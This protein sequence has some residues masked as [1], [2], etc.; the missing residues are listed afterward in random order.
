MYT[1]GIDKIAVVTKEFKVLD[2]HLLTIQPSAYRPNDPEQKEESILFGNQKGKKAFF[3]HTAFNTTIDPRGIVVSLNPSKALHPYNLTNNDNEIQQV[4]DF[5]RE[6]MKDAG[7]LIPPDNELKLVRLDMA[8]NSQM[9]FPI[10]FYAPLFQSLKGKRMISKEY[11]SSYYFSN[12]QREINFY[13]KTEEVTQRGEDIPIDP[14][15]MRGELRA[16]KTD[17][18]GRM[19]RFNDLETMLK[20]GGEYRLTKYKQSLVSQIFADGN[21]VDQLSFFSL[22]YARELEVLKMYKE[23][24]NRN[25]ILEWMADNSLDVIIAKFGSLENL[26]MCL[27]DAGYEKKYTFKVIRGIKERMQFAS[28]FQTINKEENLTNLYNEVFTKFAV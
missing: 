14:R 5:V 12:N 11:P 7:I 10:Q 8:I 19:Y 9:A 17:S 3:N 26:R 15:L 25:A 22:D 4:W 23:R 24:Y 27:V 1:A 20:S 2:G 6:E 16:K 13:D 21:R 28:F 18:I